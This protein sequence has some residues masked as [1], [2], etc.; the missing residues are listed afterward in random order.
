MMNFMRSQHS[1]EEV[2]NTIFDKQ[3]MQ[4]IE[5]PK[6]IQINLKDV[7]VNFTNQE[8]RFLCFS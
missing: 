3:L 4:I 1:F 7:S 2:S 6:N 5:K 8:L